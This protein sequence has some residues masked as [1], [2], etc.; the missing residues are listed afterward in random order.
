MTFQLKKIAAATIFAFLIVPAQA[1]KWA[2]EDGKQSIDGKIEL[3]GQTLLQNPTVAS[4]M[5]N[6]STSTQPPAIIKGSVSLPIKAEGDPCTPSGT[7]EAD[8]GIAIT[9]DRSLLLSCQSGTWAK[10]AVSA[11]TIAFSD[12]NSTYGGRCTIKGSNAG[13]TSWIQY[14]YNV[15]TDHID[16]AMFAPDSGTVF[17]S[18]PGGLNCTGAIVLKTQNC[19]S[20]AAYTTTF[21]QSNSVMLTP[22]GM[23]VTNPP[24]RPGVLTLVPWM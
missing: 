21:G 3:T 15:A 18:V 22:A 10:Q 5:V 13:E 4:A 17:I 14:C 2:W 16:V 8:E 11:G 20:T 19:I 6:A 23:F 24:N 9:V 1:Q 7:E 12:W